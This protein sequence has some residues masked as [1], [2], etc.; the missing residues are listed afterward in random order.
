MHWTGKV[1]PIAFTLFGREVA[2]YGIIITTAILIGLMVSI[3]RGKKIKLTSDDFLEVF[4]WA[5][6]LAIV[7]GRLGFVMV[8]P[9]QYFLIPG[10]GFADFINIFAIWDGGITILTAVPGGVL[11]G[12]LWTRHRKIDFVTVADLIM[13]V[14]LLSQALG[15][16]GNFFNQ[17]IYG[18]VITNTSFQFF[19]IAVFIAKT[20]NFHVAA[21]F[22]EMVLNLAF[23]FG[24]LYV[25]NRLKVRGAGIFLY[26]GSYALIRFFMEF[27][28]IEGFDY[29]SFNYVQ[30]IVL[31]VALACGAVLFKLIMDKKKAG[32]KVWYKDKIPAKLYPD[33]KKGYVDKKAG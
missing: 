21:F 9:E 19:P 26:T 8:R 16:W 5:I 17:E 6:P 22:V 31:L 15:R 20:G 23:F 18:P 24:L 10:F 4:L 28:R 25:M 3:Q 7:C 30:V 12:Y 13:P 11:G 32:K 14:I 27:I 33:V 29:T 2:W 1:S